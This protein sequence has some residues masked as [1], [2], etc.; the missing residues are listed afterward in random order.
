MPP[1]GV[2]IRLEVGN[3]GRPDAPKQSLEFWSKSSGKKG[4]P[5]DRM[6]IAQQNRHRHTRLSAWL[7]SAG[8]PSLQ[9]GQKTPEANELLTE[10]GGLHIYLARDADGNVWAGYTKGAPNPKQ[11]QQSFANVLWGSSPGGYWP[12][13]SK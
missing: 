5:P 11:Q 13:A 9:P 12:E 2:P 10:I 3:Q 1:N 6:R 7:P 8:F 4:M